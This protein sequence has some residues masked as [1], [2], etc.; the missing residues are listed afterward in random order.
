MTGKVDG[1][2]GKMAAF[3]REYLGNGRVA[4]Q[5]YRAAYNSKG[6][7]EYCAVQGNRLIHHR[8]IAPFIEAAANA[9][10]KAINQ[11]IASMSIDKDGIIQRLIA[12]GT[13]DSRGLFEMVPGC[14]PR[15]KA[16]EEMSEAAAFAITSIRQTKDGLEIKCADKRAALMDVAKLMGLVTD[17]KVLL[18]PDGKPVDLTPRPTVV[19]IER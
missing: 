1:L 4:A 13:Y 5:A 9:Q 7:A 8:K 19:T 12:L 6:S 10:R 14:R 15:L 3:V 17:A 18:G 16:L 11:T 2:T